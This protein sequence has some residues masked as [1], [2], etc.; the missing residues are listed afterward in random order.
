MH[1]NILD[2]DYVVFVF[3]FNNCPFQHFI[4]SGLL[5]MPLSYYSCLLV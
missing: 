4:N 3:F 1:I 2:D 5:L